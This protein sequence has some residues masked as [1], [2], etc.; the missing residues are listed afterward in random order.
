MAAMPAPLFDEWQAFARI[1]P[2]GGAVADLRQ[3]RLVAMISAAAGVARDP[4][5]FSDAAP[6]EPDAA[7]ERAAVAR[8][9]KRWRPSARL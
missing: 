1:E 6:A 7:A 2:F 3:A 4:A 5:D 8:K 9:M